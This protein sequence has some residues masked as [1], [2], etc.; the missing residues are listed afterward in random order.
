MRIITLLLAVA[1][2][3]NACTFYRLREGTPTRHHVGLEKE[4]M[5]TSR[6]FIHVGDAYFELRNWRRTEGVINGTLSK[7]DAEVDFYYK[8]ALAVKN[9]NAS[10][11]E[12]VHLY[13][14][15]LFLQNIS[16]N[17]MN[18][19]FDINSVEKV[20]ILD[21]NGALTT[22]ANLTIG[23]VSGT[24][25]IAVFLAI[26]CS[27][28]HVYLNDGENWT[29]SNSMFT[30]A[31]NPTL[32]RY[33][34]KKMK[35]YH[36]EADEIQIEI[37]N[38][39]QEI[40]MTNV[41]KLMAVYHQKGEEIL[42]TS[43]GDLI[44]VTNSVDAR[45]LHSD[46][47]PLKLQLISKKNN[48]SFM[49]NTIDKVGFS[50][51]QA[52]FD[53]NNK[54]NV[55]LIVGIKNPKWGGYVYHEFTKFF[56][57]NYEKWVKSNARKSKK[58]LE[59]NI[60]KAGIF[61]SVQVRD[62][63][64]WKTIEHL[65]LVGEANFEKIAISIPENYLENEELTIRLKSGFQFWEINDLQIAEK[66]DG[67]IVM[68]EIKAEIVGG[69]SKEQSA[70]VDSDDKDYLVHKAGEQALKIKFSGIKTGLERTLFLKSKGYYKTIQK[71]EGQT[72]WSQLFAIQKDGGLSRFSVEKWQDWIQ[73]E[74]TL[75]QLGL[76][77]HFIQPKK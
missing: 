67:T 26:A 29:F 2:F 51:L 31:M 72:N 41:L 6:I 7:V 64:K 21:K 22:L 54:K 37:R 33:D 23:A 50:N 15:H 34:L 49:F 74:Q 69:K 4:E 8:K 20:Q 70:S 13:Q 39:E 24:G 56:G 14:M 5:S 46:D 10:Q 71:M 36:P 63:N 32:E 44:K 25:A 30:G 73:I 3:L 12:S 65:N 42:S 18:V 60:E 40:Q 59:K 57:D 11:R 55:Q 35:D 53:V 38:E 66:V 61:L 45:S 16:V 9:F 62:K 27:C 1:F 77:Q 58:Q 43:K 52:T 68:E 19:S 48:D 47:G 28:P 17:D 76:N 75:G